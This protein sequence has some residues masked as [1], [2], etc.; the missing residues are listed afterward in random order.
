MIHPHP[1]DTSRRSLIATLMA[2]ALV[3]P[4]L[5]PV[6]ASAQIRPAINT[7]INPARPAGNVRVLR[8]EPRVDRIAGRAATPCGTGTIIFEKGVT[9]PLLQAPSA[10][11]VRTVTAPARPTGAVG[12][13]QAAPYA[14]VL[15]GPNRAL[16][17]LQFIGPLMENVRRAE[18]VIGNGPPVEV[19]IIGRLA[20]GSQCEGQ[21]G[22]GNGAITLSLPLPD[23]TS[24]TQARIRLY[25][26]GRNLAEQAM[27]GRLCFLDPSLGV[28]APVPCGEIR[29]PAGPPPLAQEVDLVIV[30]HPRVTQVL[31][32]TGD[33]SGTDVRIGGR[34]QVR[35]NNFDHGLFPD[36]STTRFSA[37]RAVSRTDAEW[38][39]DLFIDFPSGPATHDALLTLRVPLMRRD[40]RTELEVWDTAQ[41][42]NGRVLPTTRS[43]RF[44]RRAP[45]A[46]PPPPPP[47]QATI[48]GFD[49]GNVLYVTTGGTTT[50]GNLPGESDQVL[51][52]LASQSW[53]AAVPQPSP[54]AGGQ[55]TVAQGAA[56]LGP[57]NWGIRNR[58]N[59]AFSGT[60]TAELRLGNQAVDRMTF[61]GTLQPGET[62]QQAFRRPTAQVRVARESLGPVCYHVGLESDPVVENRG[63]TVHVTAPA[64]ESERLQS[65]N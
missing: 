40:K 4:A 45:P 32:P 58:G 47:P 7:G 53:C 10:S 26:F 16:S 43:L 33:F 63:Y 59:A 15:G 19:Q 21:H 39:G 24:R 56:T 35:G 17:A 65:R 25:G 60:V 44:I 31:A 20:P 49:P 14:E 8:V 41:D 5:L 9:P 64:S 1:A 61:N 29:D 6:P 3:A 34:V 50:V 52:A 12:A 46:A 28:S 11:A 13:A 27:G 62:R 22:A 42:N 57:I 2:G 37:A 36:Q 55:R 30:P 54:G 38:V 23:V 48:D 18:L 51:T